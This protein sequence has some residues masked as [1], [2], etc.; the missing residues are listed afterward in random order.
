MSERS[1]IISENVA[2]LHVGDLWQHP[3]WQGV[4]G[5]HRLGLRPLGDAPWLIEDP[6]LQKNK[7]TMLDERYGDVVALAANV[8][9]P[10]WDWPQLDDPSAHRI[11]WPK[12]QAADAGD[13]VQRF[14][15]AIAAIASEIAEDVCLLDLDLDQALIAAC[16]CAPSYWSLHQKIGRTLAELHADVDGLNAQSGGRIRQFLQ[17]LPIAQPFVRSNWFVHGDAEYFHPEAETPE[18]LGKDPASWW[19]RSERQVLFKPQARYVVFT[20][21]VRTAPLAQVHQHEHARRAWL[22]NLATLS[23]DEV[24]YFGGQQKYDRLTGYLDSTI[25]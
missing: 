20:I 11:R 5:K 19:V 8:Q 18:Q 2:D 7:R 12:L 10:H 21:L 23:T 13:A 15:H 6:R 25:R 17:R 14:P 24:H 3:P 22:D 1:L 9:Q 16:V 4:T